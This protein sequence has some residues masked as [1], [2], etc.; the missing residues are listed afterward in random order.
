MP[1]IRPLCLAALLVVT[2]GT[3]LSAQDTTTTRKPFVF[4]MTGNA[5]SIDA[6]TAGTQLVGTRSWGMQ[7]DGGL[8]LKRYFYLGL[9]FGPQFLSDKATFT[10]TTTGGTKSSG[11]M[12]VYFSA[13]AGPRTRPFQLVPGV[14]P[15]ALGLYGGVS[16][17]AAERSIDNCLDCRMDKMTIPGGAFVQPTMVFGDGVTRVRISDRAFVNGTGIQSVISA[18]ME[19]GAR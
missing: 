13:V 10:Q 18:G 8:L 12:L 9:D 6:T 15:I 4:G 17:T 1:R 3:L 19:L 11:A 7:F 5:M 2:T 14:A 16:A